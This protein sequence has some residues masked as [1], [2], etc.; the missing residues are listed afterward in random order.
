MLFLCS[1]DQNALNEEHPVGLS[2]FLDQLVS[3][4]GHL[5]EVIHLLFTNNF[6]W[7]LDPVIRTVRAADCPCREQ[8]PQTL[9]VGLC[10]SMGLEKV[11]ATCGG[12]SFLSAPCFQTFLG[13]V[14]LWMHST[15]LS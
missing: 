9:R 6:G 4:G 7:Y 8:L 2:T 15:H 10:S 1:S 11:S 3:G 12:S 13:W 14:A 5:S